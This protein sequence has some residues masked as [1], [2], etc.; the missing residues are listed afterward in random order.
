M[1]FSSLKA[2]LISFHTCT[3]RHVIKTILNLLMLARTHNKS[4]FC[5]IFDR[6]MIACK[7]IYMY[8]RTVLVGLL[9]DLSLVDSELLTCH[10]FKKFKL[11]L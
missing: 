8:N 10:F 4:S 3:Q 6:I 1:Y 9:L 11:Q 7:I 2:W 5:T